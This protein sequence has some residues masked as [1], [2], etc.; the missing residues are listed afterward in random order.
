MTPPGEQTVL[1]TGSTDGLGKRVAAE[2][3]QRGAT[4]L[5]HGRDPEKVRAAAA[6]TGAA[7]GLTADLVSLARVRE[8]AGQIEQLD[9]LV[10]NAGVI[11]PRAPQRAPTA[12]SSPS[13][14]TTCRTSPSPACSC[15][16]CAGRRAS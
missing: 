2:L 14:S 3:V 6:E 12:T 11:V 9:V 16:G 8:L 4:V 7:Q 5:V 1:V 13:R 15:P 10:N